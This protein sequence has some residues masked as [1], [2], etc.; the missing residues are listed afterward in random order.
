MKLAKVD[1]GPEPA[2]LNDLTDVF[3]NVVAAVLGL[4][5]IA[6]FIMLIVGGFKYIT[7]GG[8]PKLAEAARNTLT[9]AIIGLVVVAS[10][11]LIL[12]FI[13]EFTGANILNFVIYRK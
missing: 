12:L 5:G 10:A 7:S 2:Q 1:L 11:Y 9:F 13:A 6:L 4:A 8:D 3:G